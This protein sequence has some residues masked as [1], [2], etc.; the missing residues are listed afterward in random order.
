M[1]RVRGYI[2]TYMMAN[3]RHGALYTG[4]SSDLIQRV[5]QHREGEL[6]GFTKRYGCRRLVWFEPHERVVDAI[7]GEKAIKHWSRQW[8]V[9]LIEAMNPDWD[10]LW[11]ELIR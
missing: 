8:K 3:R 1:A 2:A 5:H 9:N 11:S 6:D 10:D 4:V 7:A